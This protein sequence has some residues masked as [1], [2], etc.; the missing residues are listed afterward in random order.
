MRPSLLA[1]L[2]EAVR[3]RTDARL[4]RRLHVLERDSKGRSTFD[5]KPVIVFSSNDYLGLAS[6]PDLAASLDRAARMHGLG[7]GAAH[8]VCGHHREHAAL[9]EE[10]AD[11]TGRERALLFSSGV[12]ANLGVMQTLLGRTG[13]RRP[14]LC[15]QDRL[16]HASLIDGARA[17]DAT[18]RRYPHGDVAAAARM[19]DAQPSEPALLATDGVFSM[20]GDS[21]PLPDL[22]ELCRA[23]NA[24][25]MV[26]DAHGLGV[27][28]REGA[29][30][31]AEAGLSQD[32][33][34][35]LMG[36]LG[37]A[38]GTAGAFVAGPAS[39]IDGLV[40]YARS[41]IY[42]TAPPPALA[43]A[44]R[45]AVRLLRAADDRRQILRGH[46]ERFRR[47]ATQLGLPLMPSDTPI[48]PLLLGSPE[49]AL[50]AAGQ[51]E[52]A[53]LLVTAIR[54]PTVPAGQAR[55]RIT[56]SAAHTAQDIDRL[57]DALSVLSLPPSPP[58][59]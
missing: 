43:A 29:G 12:A 20:D 25:L 6:H 36:T 13:E 30:S 8:L 50:A 9:E 15:L 40:Q 1:Q 26:D 23:Q 18:L 56:L 11:W 42:S 37:K 21:A 2:D 38:V 5:G 14:G 7:S 48:Q 22:A 58:P 54:P 46:I 55:L 59:P 57:L 45:V 16:N 24:I 28:G 32:Q 52:Q 31:T 35:V 51:L 41:Y 47:G 27:L 19:L 39:L 33:V 49:R 4:H 34:P 10:L 44:T 3:V 53:G 17:T